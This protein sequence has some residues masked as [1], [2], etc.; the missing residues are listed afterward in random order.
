M[1]AATKINIS[2]SGYCRP[3]KYEYTFAYQ[4]RVGNALTLNECLPPD[5]AN[6][7]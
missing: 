5:E 1:K 7:L 4:I 2:L 6:F 3:C